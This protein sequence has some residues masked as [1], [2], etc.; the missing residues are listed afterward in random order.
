[1]VVSSPGSCRLGYQAPQR[2][3]P[4]WI[5][6]LPRLILV[7]RHSLQPL[8]CRLL[9]AIRWN[10]NGKV[11]FHFVVLMHADNAGLDDFSVFDVQDTLVQDKKTLV[12]SLIFSQTL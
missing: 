6:N 3:P 5:E 12:D 7:P 4:L 11:G 8:W 1:M 2:L 9:F 10:R